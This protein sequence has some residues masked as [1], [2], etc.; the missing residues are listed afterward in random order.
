METEPNP[1]KTAR[2]PRPQVATAAAKMDISSLV[3]VIRRVHA[4]C[5][6]QVNRAVNVGFTLWNWAIGAYICEYEQNGA[7]QAQYGET[8][9]GKLEE[10]L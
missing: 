6:A 3:D 10:P 9:L 7:D 4:Q 8:R 2:L 5:T 1:Q